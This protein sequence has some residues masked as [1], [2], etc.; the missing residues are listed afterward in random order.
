MCEFFSRQYLSCR[1]F[2]KSSQYFEEAILQALN[3]LPPSIQENITVRTPVL[4]N[5]DKETNTQILEDLPNSVDLKNFLISDLS[6]GITDSMARTLGHAMGSWLRAFHTWGNQSAQL[7]T[8]ET[9]AGNTA[10]RDL[11]FYINYT[12]LIDTIPNF[13]GILEESRDVFEKVR[14]MAADE[15]KNIDD[16]DDYGIIH[17]DFWTGKYVPLV[18]GLTWYTY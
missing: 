14:D 10:M 15:L 16:T 11:K 17:G 3:D 13:P 1:S 8:K 4:L 6:D 9:I 5:F 12:M 2:N 18:L 7:K